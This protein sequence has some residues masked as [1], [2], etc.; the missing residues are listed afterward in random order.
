MA[1]TSVKV[2]RSFRYSR[3]LAN[4]V[5]F[6]DQG[7]DGNAF[8][9]KHWMH[10]TRGFA[11]ITRQTWT[12]WD[13]LL[14]K[15]DQE[16][17]KAGRISREDVDD[18]LKEI[19]QRKTVFSSQALLL[20]QCCGNCLPEELPDARTTLVCE[21]WKTLNKA[22]VRIDVSHYNALMQVHLENEYP[23]S[24]TEIL[25]EIKSRSIRPNRSLAGYAAGDAPD[26]LGGARALAEHSK[27]SDTYQ[28][29]IS[30]YCQAGEVD[31][32]AAVIELMRSRQLSIG[33][34]V[35]NALIWGHSQAFDIKSS[36]A[37]LSHMKESGIEPT[38]LTYNALL[39]AY[40]KHGKIDEILKTLDE[41]AAN[42]VYL[43][44]KYLLEVIYILSTN[45]HRDFVHK[46]MPRLRKLAGYNSVATKLILRLVNKGEEDIAYTIFKTLHRQARTD[47][48]ALSDDG[49]FL[50]KQ[51]VK[52]RRPTAKILYVCEKLQ[53]EGL[54][55]RAFLV[56]VEMAATFGR[57]DIALLLLTEVQ[58]MGVPLK[59]HNFWPL[60]CVQAAAGPNA[61]V[62][63]LRLMKSQFGIQPSRQTIREYVVP[64]MKRLSYDAI[65]SMLRTA[66]VSR[67][68][69]ITS[70]LFD[71]IVQCKMKE[72]AIL[73]SACSVTQPG[74]F[75][76]P[77]ADALAKT[78]DYQSYISIVRSI[79][80]NVSRMSRNARSLDEEEGYVFK[81][82]ENFVGHFAFAAITRLHCNP[83]EGAQK[84]LSALIEQGMCLS[85]FYGDRIQS[86]LPETPEISALLHELI[87][88][89]VK[90]TR[91]KAQSQPICHMVAKKPPALTNGIVKDVALEDFQTV[92]A[93][94][95]LVANNQI[96]KA[97]DFLNARKRSEHRGELR[98]VAYNSICYRIL[99]LLA[100]K[101]QDD[102]LSKIFE[103]ME[104]SNL[105]EINNVLV[106]PLIKVHLVNNDTKK[107]LSAFTT[108]ATKY[109]CTP[110]TH[111]LACNL[112][113]SE[114]EN[115]LKL[116]T[117][118]T[119][120]IHGE[121]YSLTNLVFAYVDC[122]RIQPARK[123]LK[124]IGRRIL[125]Q[126]ITMACERFRGEGKSSSLEGLIEATKG[127]TY[128]DRQ[129][130]FFNLLLIYCTDESPEKA[131]N[132]W[133]KMRTDVAP[134]DQFLSTLA[135]YL[136]EKE[137]KVPFEIHSQKS[138]QVPSLG[139]SKKINV[140]D[141]SN[142]LELMLQS[143]RLDAASQ[144]VMK[145]L[146]SN[147]YPLPHVFRK[148]MDK[149]VETSNY[150]ILEQISPFLPL[151]V[152]KRISFDNRLCD[153]Y[154]KDGKSDEYIDQMIR[155]FEMASDDKLDDLLENFPYSSVSGLF[156]QHPELIVKFENFAV[157][158]TKKGIYS[159]INI[160]WM[161]HIENGNTNL[162]KSITENFLI[163]STKIMFRHTTRV[164]R[165]RGDEKI[166]NDLI[167]LVRDSKANE[168]GL[169]EVHSCLI[170]VLCLR[171]KYDE[172]LKA[173]ENAL[174]DVPLERIQRNTLL[175]VQEGIEKAGK[176]FPYKVLD[177]GKANAA[178]IGRTSK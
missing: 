53:E 13:L 147:I 16:I 123:Y 20:I 36:V 153:I 115:N 134:T 88:S 3:L 175:K 143:N 25:E 98:E 163:H 108:I 46:V 41:C 111:D 94:H 135:N 15:L 21:V 65:V 64:N 154:R 113:H 156:G 149:I 24:P 152:K 109:N 37:I 161:H 168:F 60:I 91:R 47:D 85:K 35:F 95:E 22:N 164:A 122:G 9:H 81:S 155:N 114:D 31:K 70:C 58:K 174:K 150:K 4:F 14:R 75:I 11:S 145:L 142:I 171:G 130:M 124:I 57:L 44:D 32:A 72:A 78:N 82:T 126:R 74:L 40:A 18:V 56:A 117:E 177:G 71:A 45:D 159:P 79:C 160:I 76:V 93:V 67:S 7:G 141:E 73:V 128:L 26:I 49:T 23:F 110:W 17:R 62:S 92:E 151:H 80:D 28:H 119:A 132:L 52:A 146:E 39:C 112:I 69:A 30:C 66:G 86:K 120:K 84:I 97:I 68:T 148:Y 100:E 102:D 1:L 83:I 137:Q 101:G 54:N 38:V 89:G 121:T 2:V 162:A 5:L 42:D 10:E 87:S 138:S 166:A 169:G 99:N 29:M 77:L 96:N 90:Q 19:R 136:E 50:I 48:G 61:V 139:A 176:K 133:K 172:A 144:H 34:Q 63:I 104:R 178:N 6:S 12:N 157:N 106:G 127:F 129:Q 118:L 107:A 140:T 167:K 170:D 125:P 27:R 173:I 33:E 43:L 51:M 8:T 116:L 131:L 103:S 59:S 55:G 165:E 158:M 105:L